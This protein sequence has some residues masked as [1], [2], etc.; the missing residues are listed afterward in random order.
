MRVEAG[1]HD[2]TMRQARDGR[3]QLCGRR[4]RAGRAGGD[5]GA[6]ERREPLALFVDQPVT[7]GRW[8]YRASVLEQLWPFDTRHFQEFECLLPVDIELT[9]HQVV[10]PVPR[11]LP[12]RHVIDQACEV[13][14]ER[15]RRRRIVHDKRRLAGRFRFQAF[16]PLQHE[17]REQHASL[18][19]VQC[20][21]YVERLGTARGVRKS[22]FVRIGVADYDDTR[23]H[24]GVALEYIE[25]DVARE[26]SRA[27][28]RQEQRRAAERERVARVA[29]TL[30]QRAV[31]E[32]TDERR[33]E[34]RRSR[35]RE[36]ARR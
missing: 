36:D 12:G 11:H 10:E 32:R 3:E 24:G 31:D 4:H 26:P 15:K 21:R 13:V 20:F 30:D 23:Q 7:I 34:L 1:Q 19:F 25:E 29:K 2:R 22:Q 16:R 14:G 6:V 27:P 35:N 18:E 28:R 17:L 8:I 5:H 33:Q 9:R